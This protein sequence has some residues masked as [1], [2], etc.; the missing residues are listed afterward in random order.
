MKT[1]LAHDYCGGAQIVYVAY[2]RHQYA[3]RY[4][5]GLARAWVVVFGCDRRCAVLVLKDLRVVACACQGA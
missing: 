3:A 4:V 5:D 1:Q 2:T